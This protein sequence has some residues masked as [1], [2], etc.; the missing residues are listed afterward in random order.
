MSPEQARGQL[1]D[2]RTDLFSLGTVLYQMATGVLPFQ[3]ET[4][5]V[6]FEAI[7]NREPAPITQRE[8]RPARRARAAP[9][10]GAREGPEPALPERD[11]AQDGPAAAQAQDR[12]G[13]P[14][15]GR[16]RRVARAA[17]ARPAEKSLAVLYFENLSGRRRTSTC[18][19]ASPRTSSRSSARSRALKVALAA[20]LSF[21]YRDKS[22][23]DRPGRPAARRRLRARRQPAPRG[24]RLRINAELVD[25]QT[26]S[27]ALVRALRPRDGGRLRGA[28]R[29]RA[30]DRRGAADHAH[31]RRSRRRS[32]PSRP[33]TRRPT[34]S[35]CAAAATRGA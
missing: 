25:A 35:S 11:R 13:R 23:D 12:L 16:G 21:P 10:E 22:G 18:A 17:P 24:N 30:Q 15:R 19:T 7:L 4:S 9:R 5:A 32:R 1:T 20:E 8:P 28:G 27:L 3:G 14:A 29:D 26:D 6:V 31:A 34:T 33:R 2:A